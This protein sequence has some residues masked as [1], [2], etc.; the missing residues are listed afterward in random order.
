MPPIKR[1]NLTR[2]TNR[3]RRNQT[4]RDSQTQV[5]RV[6]LNE[7]CRVHMKQLREMVRSGLRNRSIMDLNHAAFY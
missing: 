2:Y 4:A 7:E 3:V 6:I 5:E 1:I